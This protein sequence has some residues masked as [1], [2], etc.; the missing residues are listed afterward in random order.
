MSVNQFKTHQ[1]NSDTALIKELRRKIRHCGK[2][3]RKED[4]TSQSL[5]HP[6]DGYV[7]AYD[8]E[9]I[10]SLLDAYEE[11]TTSRLIVRLHGSEEEVIY[12]MSQDIGNSPQEPKV[13]NF[14]ERVEQYLLDHAR[15]VVVH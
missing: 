14:A 11:A 7:V 15:D 8:V 2:N 13:L 10:E 6:T 3:F 1:L 12:Q 4:D 5:F 9:E